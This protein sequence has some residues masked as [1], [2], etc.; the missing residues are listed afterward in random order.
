MLVLTAPTCDDATDGGA[1][2]DNVDVLVIGGGVSGL[3]FVDQ[4][5]LKQQQSK[6]DVDSSV[7]Q[8]L[9]RIML[10]EASAALGGRV[11]D[12]RFREVPTVWAGLGMWGALA[13]HNDVW[14][15]VRRFKLE[16]TAFDLD[17]GERWFHVRGEK[18]RAS[19][20]PDLIRRHFPSLAANATASALLDDVFRRRAEYADSGGFVAFVRQLF[21]VDGER[22]LNLLEPTYMTVGDLWSAL[23]VSVP[24]TAD[25][26]LHDSD[27]PP[28]GLPM[29]S[30]AGG[31]SRLVRALADDVAELGGDVRLSHRVHSVDERT[32]DGERRYV[33]RASIINGTAPYDLVTIRAKAVVFATTVPAIDAMSGN[34]VE[35]LQSSAVYRSVVPIE[36]AQAVAAWHSAF[37]EAPVEEGG[38]GVPYG[39][40]M[41]GPSLQSSDECFGILKYY[42]GYGARNETV[43]HNS[44]VCGACARFIGS[45]IESG[46][47]GIATSELH[48]AM[49]RMFPQLSVQAPID[50]Q[51]QFWPAGWHLQRP[52]TY[53]MAD[54]A[55]WAVAPLGAEARIAL[56]GE[57][58]SGGPRGWIDP[59]WKLAR[60]VLATPSFDSGDVKN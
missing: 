29:Q 6:K 4:L 50:A 3:Y 24:P 27:A 37:W 47:T 33:V 15:E 8:P 45:M 48:R 30:I 40:N 5:L 38:L 20:M 57:A 17:A 35:R 60:R 2:I 39:A 28:R 22:F 21:G 36:V 13:E 55:N 56:I 25:K 59:A 19:Q 42:S 52:F 54:V 7:E 9:P 41:P 32:I 43:A 58:F 23:D 26:P 51:F 49:V 11:R 1:L 46:H 34:V 16:P 12:V 14:N 44:Y 31:W 10:L 53:S 18:F